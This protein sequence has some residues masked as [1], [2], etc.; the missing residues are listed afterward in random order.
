MYLVGNLDWRLIYKEI[1]EE[2]KIIGIVFEK[3]VS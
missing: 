3:F 2:I 1:D